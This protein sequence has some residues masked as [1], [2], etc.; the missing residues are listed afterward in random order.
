MFH[1]RRLPPL[2]CVLV[3]ATIC[4][5]AQ[6]SGGETSFQS[7]KR[8]TTVQDA[9]QMTRLADSKYLAGY[10]S[11]GRVAQFSPNGTQF[12][13]VLR[14]GDLERTTNECSILLFQSVDA[15]NSPKPEVLL[16]M[17]SS[18]HRN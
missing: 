4:P 8:T 11:E 5:G 7:K 3:A 14:K 15:F 13:V 2:L 16:T 12:V 10:P 6:Q 18:S 9:I 17:S 1:K